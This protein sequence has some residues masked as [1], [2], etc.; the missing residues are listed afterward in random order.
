MTI[1]E[2]VAAVLLYGAGLTLAAVGS[3]GL[4][5]TLIFDIKGYESKSTPVVSSVMLGI[6]VA[7]M[8]AAHAIDQARMLEICLTS[9]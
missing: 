5:R 6:G 1:I 3:T 4:V 2:G 7:Q 8:L 9:R